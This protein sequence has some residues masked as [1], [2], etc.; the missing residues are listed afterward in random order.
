MNPPYLLA[1]IQNISISEYSESQW[2][3]ATVLKVS[4][5]KIHAMQLAK[6]LAL[7]F[8]CYGKC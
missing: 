6:G 4:S 1:E 7:H 8:N 2:D 3:T 5:D